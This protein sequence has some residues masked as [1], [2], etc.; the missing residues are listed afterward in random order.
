VP[1]TAGITVENASVDSKK[2]SVLLINS[3]PRYTQ[4]CTRQL[5]TSNNHQAGAD[6]RNKPRNFFQER[7]SKEVPVLLNTSPSTARA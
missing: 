3:I 7:L 4:F 6:M 2:Y 5:I 1:K